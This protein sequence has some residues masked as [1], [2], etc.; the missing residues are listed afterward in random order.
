MRCEAQLRG[1]NARWDRWAGTGGNLPRV[2]LLRLAHPGGVE[3]HQDDHEKCK[4]ESNSWLQGPA[5][6]EL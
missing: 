5:F 3:R 6:T 4:I 2:R 1:A